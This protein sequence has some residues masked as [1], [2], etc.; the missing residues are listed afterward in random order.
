[1]REQIKR[2]LFGVAL[3]AVLAIG[4]L[5]YLRPSFIV[6]LANRIYLCF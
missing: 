6:D 4:F 3:A 1:M 2:F 5:A